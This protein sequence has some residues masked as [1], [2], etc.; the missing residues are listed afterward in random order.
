MSDVRYTP[1]SGLKPDIAPC[2]LS[3]DFV[4]KVGCKGS[5]RLAFC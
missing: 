3:A 5:G 1:E 2:L 4:A